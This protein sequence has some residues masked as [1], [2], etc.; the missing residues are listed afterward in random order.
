MCVFLF[1]FF[2]GGGWGGG[3]ILGF[4]VNVSALLLIVTQNSQIKSV[5]LTQA[6]E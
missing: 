4:K 2:G 3:S 6:V 1:V 5:F